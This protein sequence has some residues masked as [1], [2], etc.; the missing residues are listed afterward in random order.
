MRGSRVVVKDFRA[1]FDPGVAL[2]STVACD[3]EADAHTAF[4]TRFQRTAAEAATTMQH[5]AP[6]STAQRLRSV[7]AFRPTHA[8][9]HQSVVGL[10]DHHKRRVTAL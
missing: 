9:W 3:F 1:F 7:A 5:G 10:K 2:E 8:V 4:A 6:M